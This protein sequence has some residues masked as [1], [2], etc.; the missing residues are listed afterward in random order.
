MRIHELCRLST[1]LRNIQGRCSQTYGIEIPT[2][3]A[4]KDLSGLASD[5]NFPSALEASN[6]I[7]DIFEHDPVKVS[8]VIPGLFV[9]SFEIDPI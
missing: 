4:Q 7:E 9:L 6:Q 5:S 8:L 2:F 3:T 1:G